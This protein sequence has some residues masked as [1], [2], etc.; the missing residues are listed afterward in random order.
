MV[1]EEY[2]KDEKFNNSLSVLKSFKDAFQKIKTMTLAEWANEYHMLPVTAAESG[3]YSTERTPYLVEIMESLSVNSRYQEVIFMASAQ[4][5]KSELLNIFVGNVI[6]DNPG[7]MMVVQPST[8]TVTDYVRERIQPMIELN[9][10]VRDKM[11]SFKTKSSENTLSFKKFKGGFVTFASANSASEL[12]SKPIR[13]LALDEIDRYPND[14]D[15]QG[16][17]VGLA[18]KRTTTFSNRKI[19]KCS[20]PTT[21]QSSKIFKEIKRTD[22]KKYF[23]PC[24]ECGHEHTLEFDNFKID[25]KDFK[26]SKMCCPSCG[27]LF[28][29][30]HKTK[31]LRNGKWLKTQESSNSII[32]GYHINAFYSPIGWKS[33]EAMARDYVLADEASKKGDNSL[34]KKY[35]NLELGLPFDESSLNT[36][37]LSPEKIIEKVEEYGTLE[38]NNKIFALTAGVDIQDNRIELQLIGWS[39]DLEFYVLDYQVFFGDINEGESFKQLKEYLSKTFITKENK[40]I[41]LVSVALDTGGHYTHETYNFIREN[42]ALRC[43][44]IKGSSQRN[45]EIINRPKDVDIN[46]RGSIIKNGT[47]LWSVGTDTAKKLIFTKLNVEGKGR[48]HFGNFLSYDYFKQLTNE[49]ALIKYKNGNAYTVFEKVKGERNEALDTLVYAIAAGYQAGLHRYDYKQIDYV[50]KNLKDLTI[51]EEKPKEED[52]VKRFKKKTDYKVI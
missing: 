19:Y 5:G 48:I 43:I 7:A 37:N 35:I 26:N 25:K 8:G 23:V 29:E 17:P 30:E 36:E 6:A 42:K 31:M 3:K 11:L 21:L 49:K 44:A 33:W 13:F 45:K 27:S 38:I 1:L 46:Y 40:E 34:M 39:Y 16:D 28:G 24:P 51:E 52:K 22:Y 4:V 9:P 15:G 14:V 47:K 20:T 18:E 12:S 41:K 10:V 2:Y 32:T 50:I